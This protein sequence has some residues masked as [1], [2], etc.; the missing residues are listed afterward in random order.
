LCDLLQGLDS[1]CKTLC[2]IVNLLQ[3]TLGFS[4]A[5]DRLCD[6]EMDECDVEL[7]SQI[8]GKDFEGLL[9]VLERGSE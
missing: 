5:D 9:R 1:F 8:R 7:R 6:L 3:G 4:D 2:G